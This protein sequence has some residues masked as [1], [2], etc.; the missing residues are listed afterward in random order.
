MHPR[1]PPTLG[2]TARGFSKRKKCIAVLV[3]P[4]FR[5]VTLNLNDRLRDKP[6]LQAEVLW[7]G[8][9]LQTSNKQV[10]SLSGFRILLSPKDSFCYW[11]SLRTLLPNCEELATYTEPGILWPFAGQTQVKT[12]SLTR[13]EKP[14]CKSS[15]A[16]QSQRL[17]MTILYF[18]LQLLRRYRTFTSVQFL[19]I[20][21]FSL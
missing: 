16:V 17:Q 4:I 8:T 5:A 12:C 21:C 20:K 15:R 19:V 14:V 18:L 6:T 9:L 2:E 1:S 3:C 13:T 11:H 10:K 7:R